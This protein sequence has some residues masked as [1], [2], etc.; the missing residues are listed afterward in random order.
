[1]SIE[2]YFKDWMK[3]IDK[4]ELIKV[5]DQIQAIAKLKPVCPSMMNIFK[6]F[7]VCP[8]KELKIVMLGQDPYPQKG[9]ATGILFGNRRDTPEE[10]LSPSLQ[11]IKEA[12]INYE[13][14]HNHIIF[15]QSLESWASQ[16]ILMIN[17]ALTVEMNKIGSHT[18]I[19]R[20]FI[21]CLLK[22]L[23]ERDP[24]LIYILFGTQAQTFEPYINKQFN[25]I[26]K[27][28]HPAYFARTHTKMPYKLFTDI[29]TL[30]NNKYGTDIIWYQ[31]LNK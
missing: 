25:D 29:S 24:G 14:P 26:I 5:T 27:I 1:M 21:N 12:V 31:E 9:I 22:H 16:G 20:K 17:S 7:E 23:S 13:V 15:D 10:Q 18:M 28:E 4:T 8:Y 2:D 3:V 19:W 6:A 11:V 30:I